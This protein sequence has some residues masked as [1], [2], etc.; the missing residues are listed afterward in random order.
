MNSVKKIKFYGLGRGGIEGLGGEAPP[1]CVSPGLGEGLG[2]GV[3]LGF[4]AIIST[5]FNFM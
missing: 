5:P 1:V 4:G 3:G 2:G